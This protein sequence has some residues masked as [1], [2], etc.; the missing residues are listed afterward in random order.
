MARFS[1]MANIFTGM[2]A[3][4]AL[5]ERFTDQGEKTGW[6]YIRIPAA[7]A[8][9]LK[10]GNLK[11]FRVKGF[12]DE[13]PIEGVSLLPMGEGDFIMAINAPMRKGTGKQKGASLQVRLEVDE[14]PFVVCPDFMESLRDEPKA[15]VFFQGLAKGHQRYFSNWIESAKTEPTRVKRIAQAVNAM[16]K[17]QDFGQMVRALKADRMSG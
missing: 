11:S 8:G 16:A 1:K 9:K 13:F 14:K 10:P 4:K 17:S 15:L 3:F 6:T 2:I 12:L 5:L 7:L